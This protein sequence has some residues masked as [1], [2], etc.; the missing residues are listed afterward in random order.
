MATSG[1]G[2]LYP[3]N[4][5]YTC[6]IEY[7]WTRDANGVVS[8]KAQ[9]YAIGGGT[10][11]Y[12]SS[13]CWTTFFIR[14]GN[15]AQ[16]DLTGDLAEYCAS[17]SECAQYYQGNILWQHNDV[18]NGSLTGTINMGAAGGTLKLGYYGQRNGSN[19]SEDYLTWTVDATLPP[20]PSMSFN[21][22]T[23]DSIKLNYSAQTNGIQTTVQYK[24]GNGSWVDIS[25]GTVDMGG[26]FRIYHLK[27]NATYSISIRSHTSGGDV[28]G[29]TV[30]ASTTDVTA[31]W[32][33]SVNDSRKRAKKIYC[34]VGGERKK[35]LK[36]YGS[37]N[38]ERKL[39]YEDPNL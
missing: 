18:R 6:P 3:N 17:C 33:G 19:T 13:P 21:S 30:S 26:N 10:G 11:Q 32:Y 14:G 22:A 20:A 34:S 37:V 1:S 29:N 36:I 23:K 27:P 25:S 38:G 7:T 39:C 4:G 2:T 5:S 12:D 35:V 31:K 28:N 16:N 24:V 8:W 15:N 9:I